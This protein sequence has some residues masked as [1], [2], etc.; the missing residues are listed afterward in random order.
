M[1]LTK[2]RALEADLAL[3]KDERVQQM[4][5]EIRA[6]VGRHPMFLM[7]KWEALGSFLLILKVNLKQK[8]PEG[9]RFLLTLDTDEPEV[10]K[11]ILA[12]LDR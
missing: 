6:I 7:A 8:D 9:S 12:F 1:A 5:E 4:E 3:M 11:E 2:Q 10:I